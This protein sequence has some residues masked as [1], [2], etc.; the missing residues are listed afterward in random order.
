LDHQCQSE[1]RMHAQGQVTKGKG[2]AGS[3]CAWGELV[4][5]VSE[6]EKTRRGGGGL[7][8]EEWTPR[9]TCSRLL[10]EEQL[11][12]P[13]H[14]NLVGTF[15]LHVSYTLGRLARGWWRCIG[16]GGMGGGAVLLLLSVEN[17]GWARAHHH[18]LLPTFGPS[19][20]THIHSTRT[21]MPSAFIE[22]RVVRTQ[23]VYKAKGFVPLA[24][25]LR[26]FTFSP[27]ED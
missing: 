26:V 19:T 2:D 3:A 23:R 6:E 14:G 22:R 5:W 24:F 10:A 18:D 16:G 15:L 17:R 9:K 25:W 7:E 27:F 20:N 11:P 13:F 21:F 12:C 1:P 8:G 4:S